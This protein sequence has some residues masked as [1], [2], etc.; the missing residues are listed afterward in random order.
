M[1]MP[2]PDDYLN[3]LRETVSTLEKIGD[4]FSSTDERINY[5]VTQLNTLLAG[6]IP[7]EVRVQIEKLRE[8]IDVLT[9]VLEEDAIGPPWGRP[10]RKG[11]VMLGETTQVRIQETVLSLTGDKFTEECPFDAIITSICFHFPPGCNALVDVAVGHSEKQCFPRKGYIALDAAT[12]VFITNEIV[13]K[14]E[15]LWAE[16]RNADDTNDHTITVIFTLQRRL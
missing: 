14:D 15:L 4:R 12:P 2:L 5:A 10:P 3:Y 11:K 16:I 8:S 9:R 6:G 13:N 7:T 1:A